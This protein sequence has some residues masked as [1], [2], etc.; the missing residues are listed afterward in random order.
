MPHVSPELWTHVSHFAETVLALVMVR[1]P[2]WPSIKREF[3]AVWAAIWAVQ[4]GLR[5]K[6]TERPV[7]GVALLDPE[8]ITNPGGGR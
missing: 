1:L 4:D 8:E 6:R 5:M 7:K 2:V 3:A